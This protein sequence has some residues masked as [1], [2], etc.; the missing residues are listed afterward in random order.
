METV[1]E[2]VIECPGCAYRLKVRVAERTGDPARDLPGVRITR[3]PEHVV[4]PTRHCSWSGRA[5]AEPIS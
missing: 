5:W 1:T 4:A 3:Y 2:A